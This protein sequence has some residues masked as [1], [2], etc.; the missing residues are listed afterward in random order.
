VTQE[1]PFFR[2]YQKTHPWISFRTLDLSSS[3]ASLWLLLG[4][5]RSKCEH[6]AGVPLQPRLAEELLRIYLVKGVRATAAIEGN[7]LTEKEIEQH[8]GGGEL[9]LPPS[10]EYQKKEVSNLLTAFNRIVSMLTRKGPNQTLSCSM[11]CHFNRVV[12]RGLDLGDG[13]VGGEIRKHQAGVAQYRGAPAE[14]CEFLLEALCNWLNDMTGHKDLGD[15]GWAIIKATLAH[16]YLEWIHPFG[17]GNGR[18][19]RLLEF[20]ILVNASVPVPSAHI[21]SDYYNET[22]PEYYQQLDRSSKSGGNVIPFIV[23]AVTGFVE[24]LKK[25]LQTIRTGQWGICWRDYINEHFDNLHSTTQIRRRHLALDLAGF[26]AWVQKEKIKLLTPR[27]ARHYA[28]KT[29]RTLTR[30]LNALIEAKLIMKEGDRYRARFETILAFLPLWPRKVI[31]GAAPIAPGRPS[32]PTP[33]TP[34][35]SSSPSGPSPPSRRRAFRVP[36]SRGSS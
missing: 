36:R 6:V 11:I 12:L 27:V 29:D 2:P 28:T 24:G 7:T 18:T 33:A 1:M 35:G 34:P 13:I 17:D 20:Y 21:L 8:M 25:Q 22:R 30:D 14:D 23:Y 32:G 10:R 3:P 31:D 5:A 4:E 15:V 26:Q 19:G 9:D 16:L